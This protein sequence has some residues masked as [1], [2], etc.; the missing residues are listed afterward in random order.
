MNI[1]REFFLYIN[2]KNIFKIFIVLLFTTL[3]SSCRKPSNQFT[4]S[5]TTVKQTSY[6]D[7]ISNIDIWFVIE[8]NYYYKVED[9][10]FTVTFIKANGKWESCSDWGNYIND[11]TT[12]NT[13]K[14]LEDDS[15]VIKIFY[16]IYEIHK[17]N[18]CICNNPC[19]Y[20]EHYTPFQRDY[21]AR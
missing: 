9:Y 17:H 16:E 11:H 5:T 14:V 21:Y 3:I 1:G 20:Y 19:C 8:N 4:V 12:H 15:R 13:F 6:N 2:M 18:Y 7:S 10:I